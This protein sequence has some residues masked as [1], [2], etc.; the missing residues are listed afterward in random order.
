[1]YRCENI[2][3]SG[4]YEYFT[5]E[6][7]EWNIGKPISLENRGFMVDSPDTSKCKRENVLKSKAAHLQKWFQVNSLTEMGKFN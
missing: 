4:P 2:R 5:G 7:M 3:I 1:M 6:K